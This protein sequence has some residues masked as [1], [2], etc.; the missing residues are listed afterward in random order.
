MGKGS[1]PQQVFMHVW[2]WVRGL[3]SLFELW[4]YVGLG[5]WEFVVCTWHDVNLLHEIV[6][7][8]T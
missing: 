1:N 3:W 7:M 5:G 2:D 4:V 8:A 6:T